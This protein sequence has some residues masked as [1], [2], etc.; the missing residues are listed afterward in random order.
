[1]FEGVEGAGKTTQVRLLGDWLAGNEI[2][3]LVTREPGSTRIGEEIRHIL[4]AGEA[5]PDRTELLLLL[6]A[7][8]AIVE[9][10]IAPALAEGRVVVADRYELSTLAYQAWGRQLEPSA[11][12]QLNEFATAGLRPD[13]TLLLDVP[14]AVGEARCASGRGEPDRIERAGREFHERVAGAYRLLAGTEAGV[15]RVDGTGDPAR[16][17]DLVKAALRAR[18]PETFGRATG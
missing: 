6:A 13:L 10:M 7:R 17:H 12:R 1:M 3:H 5:V 16:V 18:F 15:V 9:S 2:P 4:L 14:V 8:S 11:V